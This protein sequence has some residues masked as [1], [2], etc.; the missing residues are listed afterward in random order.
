MILTEKTADNK[1]ERLVKQGHDLEWDGWTIVSYKPH[2]GAFMKKNGVFRN[3]IWQVSKRYEINE[4]GK[5]YLNGIKLK[6]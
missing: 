3:G 5:W 6:R 2:S 4:D 1:L